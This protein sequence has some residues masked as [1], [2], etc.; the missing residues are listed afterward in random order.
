[1]TRQPVNRRFMLSALGAATLTLAGCG[2]GGGGGGD[3][4]V[5]FSAA[6][7]ATN[8]ADN[9]ITQTYRNMNTQAAAL[10]VAVQALQ[11]APADEA[12]MN[13]AQEAWK[14]ARVPWESSEGFLFGPVDALGID[15]SIDSWPLNTADLQAFLATNPDA[16]QEDIENASD[17]LR[18]FHA[19]EY[20]LFGDG[21][22]DNDKLA[23]ELTT[24][25]VNYLVALAQAF[26]ARTQELE[27]SWTTAYGGSTAYG[28]RLKTPG[29]SNPSYTS[30]AAVVEELVN[31][32]IGIADETANTKMAE[33]M[34]AT[35]ADADTS[36]VESQYSWNS[37]TDFHNNLQ[38]IMNVYTG[39]LG[40]SW[41]TDTASAS[42]NG[43]YAFVA[44][45]DASLAARVVTEIRDAQQK[46]ALIKGD[47][48]NTTTVIS[49]TAKP[50]REQILNESGRA[51]ITA[52]IAACNTLRTTLDSDV[53]PLIAVTTFA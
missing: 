50:F 51:L 49:G 19:M 22:T 41:Q 7:M 1:M 9:I 35:L 48:D 47:G 52:A 42:M 53:L 28:A 33:P 30:Y 6:A 45:H 8:L 26:K 31:G 34:G 21:T 14:A 3:D 38:S 17:D 46:V 5:S 2:G 43:L 25:E 16:T 11:A 23:A 24:A 10:L 20:L 15:P 27:T 29:A 37:L 44:A 32:V 13:A 40:F 12:T 18:G 39:K 4:G 36:Q